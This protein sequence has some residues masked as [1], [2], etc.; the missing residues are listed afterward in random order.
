LNKKYNYNNNEY[1][2]P[3]FLS[4]KSKRRKAETLVKTRGPM[5]NCV[6]SSNRLSTWPRRRHASIKDLAFRGLIN[7]IRFIIFINNNK[8]NKSNNNKGNNSDIITIIK[9]IKKV[10]IVRIITVTIIIITI[11]IKVIIIIIKNYA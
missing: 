4:T 3:K 8:Y 10:I 11:V 2:S 6:T 9:K 5:P 1:P 7:I